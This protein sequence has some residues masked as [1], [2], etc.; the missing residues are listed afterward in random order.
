MNPSMMGDFGSGP[1]GPM[2]TGK[3]INK[4]TGQ[5]IVVRNSLI[6]GDEMVII[7]DRGQ[8]PFSEFSKFYIQASD[9]VYDTDGRVVGN[10]KVDLSEIVET[11]AKNPNLPKAKSRETFSLKQP[12]VRDIPGND[13]SCSKESKN[14][15]LIEKI[16]SKNESRPKLNLK[17]DWANFPSKELSM[18]ID[19]FDVSTKEIA[20]YIGKHLVN[21]NLLNESLNNWLDENL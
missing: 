2:I 14:F 7:S 3:W 15:E 10:K 11:P 1:G 5:T 8:I 18:L 13:E 21:S 12:I 6:D 16:F 19:Y 4:K 17:I 9:E 20:D